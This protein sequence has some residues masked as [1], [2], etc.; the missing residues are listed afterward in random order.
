MNEKLMI[1]FDLGYRVEDKTA[2]RDS[3][4]D[5]YGIGGTVRRSRTGKVLRFDLITKYGTLQLDTEDKVLMLD[6][7]SSNSGVEITS[8]EIDILHKELKEA[9]I[10][11]AD[12]SWYL[13]K[14]PVSE[15][16]NQEVRVCFELGNKVKNMTELHQRLV[17]LFGV[18]GMVERDMDGN[19]IDFKVLFE[20]G[21]IALNYYH[22]ALELDVKDMITSKQIQGLSEKL[23]GIRCYLRKYTFCEI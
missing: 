23:K 9:E 13:K 11:Q 21:T 2:F 15:W 18:G 22:D 12:T 6:M 19:V 14:Q 4:T 16:S 1:C 5:L 7:K 20:Y 8:E 17:D 10:I 3:L